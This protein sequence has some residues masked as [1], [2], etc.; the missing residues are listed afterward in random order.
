MEFSRRQVAAAVAER[1]EPALA[2]AQSHVVRFGQDW[3]GIALAAEAAEALSAGGQAARR[4]LPRTPLSHRA[5]RPMPA[6]RPPMRC[7]LAKN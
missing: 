5:P 1:N 4:W 2:L 7:L 3:M 6:S